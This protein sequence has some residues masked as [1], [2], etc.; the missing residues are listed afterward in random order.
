MVYGDWAFGSNQFT[1]RKAHEWNWC[2]QENTMVNAVILKSS[3]LG[4]QKNCFLLMSHLVYTPILLQQPKQSKHRTVDVK[5]VEAW[6]LDNYTPQN[7][8]SMQLVPT[9]AIVY[10]LLDMNAILH[11]KLAFSSTVL[12][13]NSSSTVSMGFSF[14]GETQR[15][16][17]WYDQLLLLQMISTLQLGLYQRLNTGCSS[18]ECRFNS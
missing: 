9:S 8:G 6:P 2:L 14:W 7:Q 12:S 13:H 17:K 10:S 3:A 16:S 15:R 4:F 1:G 5:S 11:M 18:R